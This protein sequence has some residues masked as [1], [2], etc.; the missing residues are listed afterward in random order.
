[1]LRAAQLSVR[2]AVEAD[3]LDLPRGVGQ[4]VVRS[5][6]EMKRLVIER[7]EHDYLTRLMREHCG[8]VSRAARAAGK[9]RR[10]LHK[11]LKKYGIDRSSSS[12]S[13]S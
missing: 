5:F 9:D 4:R 11:L 3:D 10:D 13:V 8:N 1:M 2:A 12:H 6:N 7:F